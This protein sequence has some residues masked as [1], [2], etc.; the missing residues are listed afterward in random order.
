MLSGYLPFDDDPSNPEGDNISQ[1]Y[2]YI[3][4]SPLTFPEYVSPL[5]RDLLR[6]V[7]VPDPRKRVALKDVVAHEWIKPHSQILLGSKAGNMTFKSQSSDF[8]HDAAHAQDMVRSSSERTAAHARYALPV[9]N[10]LVATGFTRNSTMG[11]PSVSAKR[12]TL[13]I[14][15][16]T[17]RKS[18]SRTKQYSEQQNPQDDSSKDSDVDCL[19][20]AAAPTMARS[21]SHSGVNTSSPNVENVHHNRSS[22]RYQAH[23]SAQDVDRRLESNRPVV[24]AMSIESRAIDVRSDFVDER[25]ASHYAHVCASSA[26]MW[27]TGRVRASKTASPRSTKQNASGELYSANSTASSQKTIE[28][29]RTLDE[30]PRATTEHVKGSKHR[31][32][33]S[34]I[35]GLLGKF[36]PTAS[37]SDSRTIKQIHGDSGR[38]M[39]PIAE[40]DNNSTAQHHVVTNSPVQEDVEPAMSAT[41]LKP[42]VVLGKPTALAYEGSNP[43]LIMTRSAGEAH[44]SE[45]HKS[46]ISVKD[47][48]HA[49][50]SSSAA[51]RVMDFFTGRRKDRL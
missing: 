26:D 14:E 2:K 47:G 23:S 6:R 11:P 39:V 15:Y 17:P 32:N 20:I 38:T 22:D 37:S 13:Q 27:S 8:S 5:A 9:T 4:E 31:R 18:S 29:Q 35:S 40:T 19:S 46:V 36:W 16:E 21:A 24:Q 12:H 30:P 45:M 50:A 34:S 51:K 28:A 25:T 42:P 41:I 3:I 33:A 7:L 43:N 49:R 44:Q 10:H 48:G 1:L